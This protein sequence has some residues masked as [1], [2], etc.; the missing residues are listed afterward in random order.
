MG[1]PSPALIPRRRP[2]GS[3]LLQRL[4]PKVLKALALALWGIALLQSALSG[5]LDLLL[6]AV[7]HPLVWASGIL[8]L[9]MAAVEI[10]GRRGDDNRT[11]G[12]WTT[13]LSIGAA[14]AVLALPPG[15]PLPIWPPTGR[16]TC[17]RNQA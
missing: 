4:E 6:R 14:L 8:L 3:G 16:P 12:R 2:A 7:F 10:R 9:L 17:W 13:W 11:C 15:P 5:R 1:Q